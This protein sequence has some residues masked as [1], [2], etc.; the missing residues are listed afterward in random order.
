MHAAVIAV[1]SGH[2]DANTSNLQTQT[3]SFFI[4]TKIGVGIKSTGL[5]VGVESN[6]IKSHVDGGEVSI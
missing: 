3:R 2:I 5:L 1:P 6:F 4:F